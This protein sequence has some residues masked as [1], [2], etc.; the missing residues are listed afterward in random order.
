MG[1]EEEALKN[2][3]NGNRKPVFM[4]IKMATFYFPDYLGVTFR[5]SVCFLF[6]QFLK[7]WFSAWIKLSKFISFPILDYSVLQQIFAI[8]HI[9]ETAIV[10][11]FLEWEKIDNNFQM[12]KTTG[13]TRTGEEGKPSAI[14]LSNAW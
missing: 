12:I 8:H 10:V 1:L 11:F 4:Q 13:S 7:T 6:C 5:S 2:H 9:E 3:Y 14:A